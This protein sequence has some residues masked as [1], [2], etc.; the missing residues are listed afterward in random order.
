MKNIII[1]RYISPILLLFLNCNKNDQ[2]INLQTQEV[3]TTFFNTINKPEFESNNI[4]IDSLKPKK[5][6]TKS[7][8]KLVDTINKSVDS[9]NLLKKSISGLVNLLFILVVK[10]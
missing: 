7:P 6:I 8:P 4:N 5:I 9:S 2:K 3:D 10:I 1:S